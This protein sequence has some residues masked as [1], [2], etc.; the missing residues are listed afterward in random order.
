MC[1]DLSE[2]YKVLATHIWCMY[3][4]DVYRF[5][6]MASQFYEMHRRLQGGM[7]VDI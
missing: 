5:N 6:S 1:I 2:I 7:M 3:V 4:V